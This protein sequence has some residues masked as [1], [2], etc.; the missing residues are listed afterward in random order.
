M[1]NSVWQIGR[2][3]PRHCEPRVTA[4]NPSLTLKEEE[5]NDRFRL[6]VIYFFE[7]SHPSLKV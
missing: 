1:A 7:A 5:D 4:D 3:E 2:I 6:S